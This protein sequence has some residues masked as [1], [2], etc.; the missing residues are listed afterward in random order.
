M[1]CKDQKIFQNAINGKKQLSILLFH[2][3]VA[4][5][6][7]SCFTHYLVKSKIS[8]G[9]LVPG[10]GIIIYQEMNTNLEKTRKNTIMIKFIFRLYKN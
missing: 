9:D 1:K 6:M 8:F 10:S 5:F 2:L 4:I 7:K 3:I